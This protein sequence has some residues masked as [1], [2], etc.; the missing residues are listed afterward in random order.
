VPSAETLVRLDLVQAERPRPE[1]ATVPEASGELEIAAIFRIEPGWHIYWR[2][3]GDSGMAPSFRMALPEGWQAGEIRW[4]A[5]REFASSGERT[6]GYDRE[7]A[8]FVPLTPPQDF[9]GEA[10]IGVECRWMVCKSICL[11]GSATRSVTVQRQA[12]SQA[13]SQAQKQADGSDGGAPESKA[14][15]IDPGLRRILEESRARLPKPPS[16]PDQVRLEIQPAT[17]GGESAGLLRFLLDAGL[18]VGPDGRHTEVG[19]EDPPRAAKFF[20][21]ES[22]GVVF[23]EPSVQ[24][25]TV[26]G[27]RELHVPLTIDPANALGRP[28]RAAGVVVESAASSAPGGEVRGTPTGPSTRGASGQGG[29]ELTHGTAGRVTE[30]SVSITLPARR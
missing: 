1:G 2:N 9:A 19:P 23:G 15:P 21:Y 11:T 8:L 20:P 18:D 22:P 3:P 5:P 28:L 7:V 29:A 26:A 13:Q 25:G 24:P 14:P 30:L 16:S 17:T 4:P 27:S 6:F 12:Q 10:T